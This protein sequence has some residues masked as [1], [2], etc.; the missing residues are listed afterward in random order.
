MKDDSF[1]D[2]IIDQLRA[3]GAVACRPMFGGHGLYRGPVFFGILFKNRLYFKTDSASLSDYTER[4]MK[5]F[6]PNPGQT[7]KRYYEVPIDLIEA[8]EE[9]AS[10][11]RRAIECR[12][13]I[14]ETKRRKRAKKQI[15]PNKM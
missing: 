8:P 2:F 14:D 1:R 10:W 6:R 7:L 12:A 13:E 11:A 5:P 3:L 9:L 15:D 4:G